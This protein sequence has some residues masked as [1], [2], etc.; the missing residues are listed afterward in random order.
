MNPRQSLFNFL[1]PFKVQK[2][3]YFTHTSL[4]PP[5][6]YCIPRD[7]TYEFETL[8]IACLTSGI[9]MSFTEKH[10]GNSP[11]LIDLDFRQASL[12]H[13]YTD[14]QIDEF[15][16]IIVS[17][18]L[19]YII[20]PNFNV[21]IMTKDARWSK[22]VVKDGI[23]II[24]PDI[25]TH[26]SIQYAIRKNFIEEHSTF[27][28]NIDTSRPI[29]DIYDKAV[30]EK[31]GWFMYGSKK[32][33]EP[34]PWTIQRIVHYHNGVRIDTKQPDVNV[35]PYVGKLSI[36]VI[37]SS[38]LTDEGDALVNPEVE[39]HNDMRSIASASTVTHSQCDFELAKRLVP[40]LNKRRAVN[41]DLWMS[42]GWC[43]YNID[44]RLCETWDEFS[45][46]CGSK[47]K[48]GE[49]TALW[50]KMSNHSNGLKMGSLIKWA[51]EDNP[52]ESK[53]VYDSW[54]IANQFKLLDPS[55]C[56]RLN[57]ILKTSFPEWKMNK[58]REMVTLTPIENRQCLITKEMHDDDDM[59]AVVVTSPQTAMYNCMCHGS[60]V[61]PKNTAL[62]IS[63]I[64]SDLASQDK[65][66]KTET[67]KPTDYEILRGIL[68]AHA[69]EH[70]LKKFGGVVYQP[71]ANCPCAFEE[72]STYAEYINSLVSTHPL[73]QKSV[74]RF[75]ELKTFLNDVEEPNFPF[76]KH[77]TNVLAFKNGILILNKRCFIP[78]VDTEQMAPYVSTVARHYI[79]SDFTYSTEAPL[80][81]SI[82]STQFQ[83]IVCYYL[84]F[85]IGRL[86]FKVKE[87][88][89]FSIM[90]YLYGI[91]NT[92]KSTVVTVISKL[93]RPSATTTI[94]E[95][96][97]E[98]FGFQ[99][100][101]NKEVMLIYD[102]GE[103]FARHLDQQMFQKM[104]SGEQISVAVKNG[105]A[106]DV[107]WTVP[108]LMCSNFF[109]RYKN[110]MGQIARRV[111][112]FM[113]NT[114]IDKPDLTLE[115]RI[116]ATE[117]PSIVWKSLNIYLDIVERHG[118]ESFW[119]FCPE[120]FKD[121]TREM[122]EETSYITKFLTA[123]PEMNKN[124]THRFYVRY[125]HGH[126]EDLADI[127]KL[128]MN[129]MRFNYPG[130]KN[131]WTS[132]YTAFKQ[133]GYDVR[134][135]HMCKSCG[136]EA[137]KGCCE[138][139]HMSNRVKRYVVKDIEIVR[140]PINSMTYIIDDDGDDKL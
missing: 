72:H 121:A 43:L 3:E 57:G 130:N 21:F 16:E 70:G 76:L 63:A 101:Y 55:V 61:I 113:F 140:E 36:H 93:F 129:F 62:C 133:L 95:N 8:Y 71:I 11:I 118:S 119:N 64:L 44:N 128:F 18:A 65:N 116:I 74:R 123:S 115:S 124:S 5:G 75:N 139:Y 134:R 33:D 10:I 125:H 105:D 14:R 79:A 107:Q 89:S 91:G 112:L 73:M 137:T 120:Y 49:C 109:L 108:M 97:E 20:N 99:N 40:I 4:D 138:H 24:I 88:D 1:A 7:C 86:F 85:M 98:V 35:G 114:Y 13:L 52:E 30:I 131:E 6:S 39:D 94:S 117:L 81:H 38:P 67:D 48:S 28:N 90:P 46:K 103:D 29:D 83:E 32:P 92:G 127:K 80:F 84:Y 87:H 50:R 37:Y 12:D 102:V 68:V 53:K 82:I 2:G 41:R 15:V 34:K 56:V 126:S 27:F 25:V 51:R 45:K 104:V 60:K 9:P 110:N 59:S 31:N 58:R 66:K 122:T 69:K 96:T 23:H 54:I 47:Y 132:D 135:M 111:V 78:Y 22:G 17:Y 136:N 77:D 19:K 106:R 42:L 100:K 26:P